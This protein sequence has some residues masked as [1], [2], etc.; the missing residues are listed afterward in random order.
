MGS[1]TRIFIVEDD[2]ATAEAM[3][4]SLRKDGYDPVVEN[5]GA[6][7]LEVWRDHPD[8]EL[9]ILDMILPGLDGLAICRAIR[10]T[11]EVPILVLTGQVDPANVVVALELG[12]DD[13]VRKPFDLIELKARIRALLRRSRVAEAKE[14]IVIG[15]LTVDAA[16]GRVSKNDAEVPLSATEFKL[17]LE[18]V[19]SPGKV[20]SRD[21]LLRSV[22]DYDYLGDSRLVDMAIKRLRDKIEDD[23]AHPLRIST[24]RGLGYRFEAA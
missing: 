18:L 7:A 3:V 6:R 22:W 10:E 15:S 11:S 4:A 23:P 16:A 8:F 20:L 12:A 1:Q 17:L 13:Y 14:L 19:K 21:R 5:D 24:V 9:V 2:T